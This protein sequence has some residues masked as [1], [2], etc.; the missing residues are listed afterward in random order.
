MYIILLIRYH[1][2]DRIPIRF[3][4]RFQFGLWYVYMNIH[5]GRC[6]DKCVKWQS[7]LTNELREDTWSTE[8]RYL[9]NGDQ[10]HISCKRT[11]RVVQ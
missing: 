7:R 3:Q 8:F 4:F 5:T 10:A 9:I 1:K 11:R 6:V 2:F